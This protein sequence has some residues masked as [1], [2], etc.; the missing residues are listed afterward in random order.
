MRYEHNDDDMTMIM[1]AM[2]MAMAMAMAIAIAV[3]NERIDLL[4][5]LLLVQCRSPYIQIYTDKFT[6]LLSELMRYS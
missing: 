6:I 5:F 3:M 4:T 2:A 1:I